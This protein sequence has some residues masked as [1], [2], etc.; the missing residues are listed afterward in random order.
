MADLFQLHRV[1]AAEEM[2]LRRA[3]RREN[4]VPFL[5]AIRTTPSF[6]NGLAF[7]GA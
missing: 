5:G 1:N 4:R 6:A 7:S 3:C 2:V